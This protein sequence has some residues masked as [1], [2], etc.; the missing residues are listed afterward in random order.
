[1]GLPP[2]AEELSAKGWNRRIRKIA[3][4]KAADFI[5]LLGAGRVPI[6]LIVLKQFLPTH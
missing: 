6:N 1:M 2:I 4:N 3:G 5:Q